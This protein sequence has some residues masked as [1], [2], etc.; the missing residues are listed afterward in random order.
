MAPADRMPAE[1]ALGEYWNALVAERPRSAPPDLDPALIDTIERVRFLD[2]ARSPDPAFI[3]ELERNLVNVGVSEGLLEPELAHSGGEV[4]LNG[5]DH[6]APGELATSLPE[7]PARLP[8]RLPPLAASASRLLAAA[9]LLLALAASLLTA[10]VFRS[11]SNEQGSDPVV[12]PA[13]IENPV[14]FIWESR[15]DPE[16][17]L[18]Q[19]SEQPL[20]PLVDPY[21]LGIDAHGN[22]WIPDSWNNTIRILAPDGS[23]R[24]TWGSKG[25]GEGEFNFLNVVA[26]NEHGSGAAAFDTAGNL[27]VADPGNYRIQKFA[28]DLS[29]LTTWGSK[30]EGEGQFLALNDLAVD[31]QGRVFALDMLRSNVQVFDANGEF[32]R[33]WGGNGTN[34][35]EFLTPYGLAIDGE[36][37]IVVADTGNHRIQKFSSDGAFL[38]A[39]GGMGT[40]PAMFR[41]PDDVA[42]DGHGRMYITDTSNN[43]VQI[44]DAQGRFL[45]EWGTRGLEP[46]QFIT[47]TGIAL[48]HA[49]NVFVTEAGDGNERVQKFRLLPPLGA[50]P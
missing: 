19:G 11:D 50:T 30:G 32:L 33:S 31:S 8:F 2:D 15:G 23:L 28:P 16:L 25:S 10:G 22:L 41:Q 40:E 48:D 4:L 14:E 35:G 1:D 42:I 39:W 18:A 26:F 36:G 3:K 13:V 24:Q 38:A 7:A 37:N 6:A 29:F 27:Y 21:H 5:R 47:P 9:V 17:T 12:L 44:L 49:G 46:G 20:L 43:R 45:S 34:P